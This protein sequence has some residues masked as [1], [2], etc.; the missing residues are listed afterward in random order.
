MWTAQFVSNVGSWIQTVGAQWL[1]L[2]LTSSATLLGLIQT[3]S[4]LPVLLFSVPAGVLGDLVDRRRLLLATQAFMVVAAATLGV[5]ALAD[6][7]TPWLLLGLIFALGVGQAFTSPTWQSLQPELVAADERQQ[8][9]SLGS[10]NQNLARAVGPAIGGALLALTS[11]AV[12]FFVNAASFCAVIVVV[13]VWRGVRTT[14]SLPREH[15]REATRAGA[16]YV[17]A[18]PALRA[19]LVRTLLLGFFAS[20]IWALL[21]LTA[22]AQLD[23]GSGGYGILLACVGV[24]ALGGAALLPS[25]RNR[26]RAGTLVTIG[27]LGLGAVTLVLAVTH[28]AAIAGLVLVVGGGAWILSLA[29][30]NSVYQ[31]TLPGWVKTRG[32]GFYLVAFQGGLAAGSFAFGLIA[33]QFSLST[34]FAVATVGLVL[35]PLAGLRF[36]FQTISTDDLLPAGEWP[37]PVLVDGDERDGPV[38]VSVEY[39]T[40]PE[41][42][43][44]LVHQL[45]DL[46][47][48]RRRT[49]ASDWRMWRDAEHPTRFV[50]QFVVASW[51][52]HLRQHERV[53]VRDQARL[54]RVRELLDPE[55]PAQVTHWV[56]PAEH[57][58]NS[59]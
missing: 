42:A 27:S 41:C 12:L 28:V 32:V 36:R 11:A 39:W 34:A 45:E 38:M 2:S 22:S 8:A 15:V 9:I 54:D 52:E 16:R 17:V 49:G 59:S 46:R 21:P 50:E 14:R 1:M 44:E 6:A 31:L 4:T 25:F 13:V 57:D 33:Q 5:L 7:V 58:R 43:D 40:R 24:G 23:L 20:A 37:A 30:L 56:V 35:G 48:S 18:S 47:F 3:A 19:V 10:V 26:F 53:T 29:T 51:N 55:H